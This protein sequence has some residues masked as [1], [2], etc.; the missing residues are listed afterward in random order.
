MKALGQ[1]ILAAL[2]IAISA[3]QG[4]SGSFG[5]PGSGLD[6][7]GVDYGSKDAPITILEFSDPS[8]SYCGLF[9]REIFPELQRE[10]V[11][12]GIVRWKHVTFTM[13][14][15]PNSAIAQRGVEC[16]FAQSPAQAKLFMATMYQKQGEWAPS[17]AA[18]AHIK[19]YAGASGLN[20]RRFSDC[21]DN[22]TIRD[23]IRDTNLA[24]AQMGIRATP[25]FFVDG[26]R[27]EGAL[28]LDQWRA[29]I[30]S[31]R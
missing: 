13:G 29:M 15:F 19:G 21:L 6:L 12:P 28:P 14:R 18:V 23:R 17:Q 10:F 11:E 16:A 3:C 4:S 24:A 27:V 26:V 1:T 9:A 22:N 2:C 8:C 31:L 7:I 20:E 30:R 25:T 5:P